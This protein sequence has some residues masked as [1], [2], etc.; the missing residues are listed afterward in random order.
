MHPIDADM[1]HNR[2]TGRLKQYMYPYRKRRRR[3]TRK[4]F[5]PIP[6]SSHSDFK[7]SREL[8]ASSSSQNLS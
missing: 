8:H 7:L 1:Q 6:Q 2:Y 3:R 4:S 5:A